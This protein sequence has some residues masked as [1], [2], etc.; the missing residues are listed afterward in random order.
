[1]AA[2]GQPLAV[3]QPKWRHLVE[4]MMIAGGSDRFEGTIGD[5]SAEL[6]TTVMALPRFAFR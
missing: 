2:L 4:A 3:L 6:R 1:L 5:E